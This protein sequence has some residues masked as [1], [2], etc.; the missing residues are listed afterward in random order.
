VSAPV[1]NRRRLPENAVTGTENTGGAD[2]ST[3]NT[4]HADF[5]I[6]NAGQ[7]SGG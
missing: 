5:G 4:G 3:E 7:A 2:F 6:E 1:R